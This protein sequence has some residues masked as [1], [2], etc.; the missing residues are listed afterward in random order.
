MLQFVEVDITQAKY[1]NISVRCLGLTFK[2]FKHIDNE[3][4]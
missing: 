3:P 1:T 2:C 4:I